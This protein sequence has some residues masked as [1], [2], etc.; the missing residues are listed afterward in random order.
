V[1]NVDDPVVPES[2]EPEPSTLVAWVGHAV[3]G[4]L[5][6]REAAAH[7]AAVAARGARMRIGEDVSRAQRRAVPPMG[8]SRAWL[9]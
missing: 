1:E 4:G 8:A 9:A 6:T 5:E 2:A 7:D 3:A